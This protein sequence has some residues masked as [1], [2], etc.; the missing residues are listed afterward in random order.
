MKKLAKNERENE[1]L[2]SPTF[3]TDDDDI[4]LSGESQPK[5]SK[6]A[7]SKSTKRTRLISLRSRI[8]QN[9]TQDSDYINVLDSL[10]VKRNAEGDSANSQADRD[11]QSQGNSCPFETG[12]ASSSSRIPEI[13]TSLNLEIADSNQRQDLEKK[14]KFE[15]TQNMSEAAS[16]SSAATTSKI[17]GALK[18]LTSLKR[19]IE[20]DDDF[21]ERPKRGQIDS[22]DTDTHTDEDDED[23]QAPQNNEFGFNKSSKEDKDRKRNYRNSSK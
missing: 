2:D 8:N 20:Q 7:N 4:D 5:T 23:M 9:L 18:S 14:E 13:D 21:F 22:V 16:C 3:S 6:K 17:N 19:K 11:Q 10:Q 15:T 12:A 1:E